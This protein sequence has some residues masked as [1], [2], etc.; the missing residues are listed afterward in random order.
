MLFD[1]TTITGTFISTDRAYLYTWIGKMGDIESL[2]F[3]AWSD[4]GYL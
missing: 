4:I 1:W 3:S 2:E